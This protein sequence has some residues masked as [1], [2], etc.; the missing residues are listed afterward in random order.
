ML[1]TIISYPNLS[2]DARV[3]FKTWLD[4]KPRELISFPFKGKHLKG[5]LFDYDFKKYLVVMQLQVNSRE[6]VSLEFA[7]INEQV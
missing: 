4:S 1:N 6:Q 3:A 7:R 2:D 5:Y